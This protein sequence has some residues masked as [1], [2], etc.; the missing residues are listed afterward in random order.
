LA[1]SIIRHYVIQAIN[2]LDLFALSGLDLD[3]TASK[4]GH[5]YM[6]VFL[7]MGW[8]EPGNFSVN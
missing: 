6:T 3:E 2:A 8:E 1:F 5:Y 4:R 7:D